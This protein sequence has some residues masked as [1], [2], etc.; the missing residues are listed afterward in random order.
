[1]FVAPQVVDPQSVPG[2]GTERT[3][4]P[5]SLTTLP[6]LKRL[7]VSILR[8]PRNHLFVFISNHDATKPA[9]PIE[10]SIKVW[11]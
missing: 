8:D 10:S 3:V 9:D 5:I 11:T 2:V 4:D 7:P 1:M 6:N